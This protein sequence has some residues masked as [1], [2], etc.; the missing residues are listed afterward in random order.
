MALYPPSQPYQLIRPAVSWLQR[1]A[2]KTYNDLL[3][4]QRRPPAVRLDELTDD[5]GAKSIFLQENVGVE[6]AG[7][8]QAEMHLLTL[9]DQLPACHR[10]VLLMVDVHGYTH[11]QAVQLLELPLS[12]IKSHLCQARMALRDRLVEVGQVA[13]WSA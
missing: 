5:S 11:A 7:M 10:D 6:K 8:R 9:I 13:G 4:Y 3:H 2:T 1:I 12:T